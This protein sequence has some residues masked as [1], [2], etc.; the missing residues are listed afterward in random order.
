MLNN[1]MG[2]ISRYDAS[3]DPLLQALQIQF[4]YEII[5]DSLEFKCN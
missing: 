2:R 4:L 1:S 5:I 3:F